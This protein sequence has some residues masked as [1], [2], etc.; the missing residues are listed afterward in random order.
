MAQN[1]FL[2]RLNNNDDRDAC[3]YTEH[4]KFECGHYWSGIRNFGAAW[5]GGKGMKDI[6]YE[7]VTTGMT[8]AQWA[9]GQ[10]ID[11]ELSELG[12]GIKKGD[13]RYKKGAKLAKEWNF[14]IDLIQGCSTEKDIMADERER[15]KDKYDFADE[16]VDEIFN[17]TDFHDS[18]VVSWVYD[19]VE[20]FGKEQAFQFGIFNHQDGWLKDTMDECFDY[21]KFGNRCLESDS[22][23]EL[24]NGKIVT[25]YC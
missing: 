15:I 9:R 13:S 18:G 14:L 6:A 25:L 17:H 2:A 3:I 23:V 22:A 1:L 20:N 24:R 7:D 16:G 10:E 12:Y 8:A 11:R 4:V 19:D 5:S 21:E